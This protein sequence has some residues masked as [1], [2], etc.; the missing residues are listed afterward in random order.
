VAERFRP[1]RRFA[2]TYQRV[3]VTAEVR[4]VVAVEPEPTL[5]DLAQA[6]ARTA[7]VHAEVRHG[8]ADALPVEDASCEAVV[9]SLVMCTT[10]PAAALAEVRR[11]PAARRTAPNL[12]A[13]EIPAPGRRGRRGHA[14]MWA[15]CAGG[16]PPNRDAVATPRGWRFRG[17]GPASVRFRPAAREPP[18]RTRQGRG[19][20]RQPLG[21][22]RSGRPLGRPA[23]TRRTPD[24]RRCRRRHPQLTAPPRL[25]R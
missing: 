23:A 19:S 7:P 18:H 22:G 1:N 15:R 11:I 8:T 21:G 2:K 3:A 14:P 17:A 5:C 20:V 9:L 25:S 16:C 4:C 10:L 6:M 13:R 24:R 12:R